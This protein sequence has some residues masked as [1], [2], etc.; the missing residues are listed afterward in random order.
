[1]RFL[2]RKVYLGV[3]VALL[4]AMRQGPTPRSAKTLRDTFDVD[5]RTLT[6]WRV[7]WQTIFPETRFW[8]HIK[9]RFMPPVD[10]RGLPQTLVDRFGTD[11][12]TPL[13]DRV[14]RVLK[15]LSPWTTAF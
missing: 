14:V 15:F 11:P 4:T 13:L 6:R 8:Q 12:G 1:V 7:W 3:M 2:G 9:A 5:R 10:H